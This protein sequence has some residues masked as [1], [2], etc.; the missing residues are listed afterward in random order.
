MK[1]NP[2]LLLRGG[3]N[4][5]ELHDARELVEAEHQ[6]ADAPRGLDRERELPAV[7]L[8]IAGREISGRDRAEIPFHEP[9]QPEEDR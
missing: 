6:V 4:G 8:Q 3:K 1:S 5:F 2:S 9:G 7:E